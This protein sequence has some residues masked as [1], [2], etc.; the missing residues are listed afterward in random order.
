MSYLY[1]DDMLMVLIIWSIWKGCNVAEA[2]TSMEIA[3]ELKEAYRPRCCFGSFVKRIETKI[4]KYNYSIDMMRERSS[5]DIHLRIGK[6]H[7]TAR[8]HRHYGEMGYFLDRNNAVREAAYGI[9]HGINQGAG[10]EAGADMYD[11]NQNIYAMNNVMSQ[12]VTILNEAKNDK[13][14]L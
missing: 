11:I 6:K 9:N 1:E 13:I 7:I 4:E 2:T 5:L 3:D 8:A 12:L 14:R 10:H